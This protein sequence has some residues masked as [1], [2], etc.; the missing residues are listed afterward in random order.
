MRFILLALLLSS[1]IQEV[2]TGSISSPD[3]GNLIQQTYVFDIPNPHTF[4]QIIGDNSYASRMPIAYQYGVS[5]THDLTVYFEYVNGSPDATIQAHIWL[6]TGSDL[7]DNANLVYSSDNTYNASDVTIASMTPFKFT[8]TD[9]YLTPGI[10]YWFGIRVDAVT[11]LDASNSIKIGYNQNDITG[12]LYKSASQSS[13]PSGVWS[14]STSSAVVGRFGLVDF[15]NGE[16]PKDVGRWIEFTPS[17][18]Q[19]STSGTLWLRRSRENLDVFGNVDVT[20][21]AGTTIRF[22]MPFGLTIDI[23]RWTTTTT[24]RFHAGTAVAYDNFNN[25][26]GTPNPESS[27]NSVAFMGPGDPIGT[28]WDNNEPFVWDGT[29]DHISLNMSLPILEWSEE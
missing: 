29:N 21:T 22:D 9:V 15:K 12:G 6:P 28:N 17:W 10:S 1:C 4:N 18:Q 2:K 23:N 25:H 19:I 16:R 3:G 20:S 13:P 5:G 11:T 7:P 8:F 26:Q 27:A 24:N 14:G